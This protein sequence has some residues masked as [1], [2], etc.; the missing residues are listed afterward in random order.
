MKATKLFVLS[1]LTVG[2]S[3]PLGPGKINW[4]EDYDAGIKRAKV[5]G[6]PVMLYFG[7]KT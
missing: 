3:T 2:L 6:K 4:Y 5:T 7:T 1:L